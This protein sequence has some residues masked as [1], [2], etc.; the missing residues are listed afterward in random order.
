MMTRMKMSANFGSV[1]HEIF[2]LGLVISG[3]ASMALA[4]SV[5]V[6]QKSA[7]IP[8]AAVQPQTDSGLPRHHVAPMSSRAKEHY[9]LIW[10]IDSLDVKAV[11]SGQ[12]IRFSY[13]VLDATRRHN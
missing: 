10:G 11:E 8:P 12:M 7:S 1:G 5:T 6:S 9:Q 4:Q 3:L 2:I 13:Y